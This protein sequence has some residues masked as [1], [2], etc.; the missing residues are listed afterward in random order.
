MIKRNKPKKGQYGYRNYQKKIQL[1]EIVLGITA[2]L[3]QLGARTLTEQESIKNIL[4]VM[5]IVSA[6]PTANI[7]A[8]FFAAIKYKTPEYEFYQNLSA[9]ED[10]ISILYDLILT[11][12]ELIMPMDG[13]I[14]HPAGVYCYCSNPKISVSQAEKWLNELFRTHRLDPHVKILTDKKVFFKRAA[15]L[16][17]EQEYEDDGSLSYTINLLKTI[18]M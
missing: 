3:L 13:I 1:I 7:A 8:P 4:T 5:A 11:S 2:I 9:F 17:P 6:I 15:S 18:S 12:K 16:K 10:R 14:V